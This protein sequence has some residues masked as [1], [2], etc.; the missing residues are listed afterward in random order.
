MTLRVS[1]NKCDA[2]AASAS[3]CPKPDG[4]CEKMHRVA[5]TN[6]ASFVAPLL[7]PFTNVSNVSSA[8]RL[9]SLTI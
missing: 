6:T 9:C 3:C 5:S 4:R 2:G 7:V 1:S 8:S